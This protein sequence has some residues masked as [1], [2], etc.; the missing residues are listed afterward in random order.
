V[1]SVAPQDFTGTGARRAAAT[2]RE[3]VAYLRAQAGLA[4]RS[5]LT[6]PGVVIPAPR[7]IQ[8]EFLTKI[9]GDPNGAYLLRPG[10]GLEQHRIYLSPDWAIG[11]RRLSRLEMK[12]EAIDAGWNTP[13]SYRGNRALGSTLAHEFGHHVTRRLGDADGNM[14]IPQAARLLP[15]IDRALGT[16]FATLLRTDAVTIQ[17]GD[18]WFISADLLDEAA[19][20]NAAILARRVSGYAGEGSYLE[21]LAEVWQEYS[22]MGA[23][24][25]P[26]IRAIGEVMQALAEAQ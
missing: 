5:V 7:T 18:R 16:D 25:R 20:R 4:P 23:L 14:G 11:H 19:R 2:E 15:V 22:T 12:N 9:A 8:S 3:L 10:F 26:E 13:S 21:F 6:M 24:T 1:V 17:L